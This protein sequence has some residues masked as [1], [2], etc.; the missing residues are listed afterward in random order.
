M[1]ERGSG[2]RK[3]IKKMYGGVGEEDEE[4][5]EEEEEALLLSLIEAQ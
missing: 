1:E 3:Y 2:G 4:D 5:D